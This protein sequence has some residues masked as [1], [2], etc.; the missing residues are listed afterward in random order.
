MLTWLLCRAAHGDARGLEL[1]LHV[2]ALLLRHRPT[3]LQQHSSVL[4]LLLDT[5]DNPAVHVT[6]VR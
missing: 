2:L 4:M 5:M 6:H 3:L 1:M